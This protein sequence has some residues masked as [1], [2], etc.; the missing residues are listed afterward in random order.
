MSHRPG[1]PLLLSRRLALSFG[2]VAVLLQWGCHSY[3]PL[4]TT[5]PAVQER[6][7]VVLSD[8]GRTMM[9]DKLGRLVVQVDGIIQSAD[10]S[11]LVLSV[12]GTR[13]V[14]GGSSLWSGERVEIPADA[15]LGYRL[16]QLSKPRSFLLAGSLVAAITVLTFGLS[17]DLFGF[18]RSGSDTQDP[19]DPGIPISFRGRGAVSLP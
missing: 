15:V 7:A 13:D 10:S 9:E 8:R 4:Q 2:A 11:A 6:A 14:R 19:L 18:E 3:L 17:L 16:R 12:M 5:P 1:V